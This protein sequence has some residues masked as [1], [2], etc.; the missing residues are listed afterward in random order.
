MASRGTP[1]RSLYSAIG[2][3]LMLVFLRLRVKPPFLPACCASSFVH[4]WAVPRCCA[5]FPPSAATSRRRS[6]ES[7]VKPRFFF[8]AVRSSMS[9]APFPPSRCGT[10]DPDNLASSA[11]SRQLP[12]VTY[13][14]THQIDLLSFSV[15]DR[16]SRARRRSCYPL[17]PWEL[18][19]IH[20]VLYRRHW[21]SSLPSICFSVSR[22]TLLSSS[23]AW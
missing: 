14:N 5:V 19:S 16:P 21:V 8:G 17:P 7:A 12:Q 3:G 11:E 20:F 18:P 6:G 9:S 15:W 10:A 13:Y 4:R 1:P 22:S 23:S 2:G